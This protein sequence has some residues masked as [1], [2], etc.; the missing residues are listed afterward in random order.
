MARATYGPDDRN[1]WLIGNAHGGLSVAYGLT[2]AEACG[3]VRDAIAE[4][5]LTEGL[6]KSAARRGAQSYRVSV[7]AGGLT[8]DEATSAREDWDRFAFDE[9]AR[10]AV[11]RGRLAGELRRRWLMKTGQRL[12]RWMTEQD[13][14]S[15]PRSGDT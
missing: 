2:A 11:T 9:T 4:A 3:E 5:F 7:T 14:A 15:Q 8:Y 10:E 12:D 13:E 6:S 1:W